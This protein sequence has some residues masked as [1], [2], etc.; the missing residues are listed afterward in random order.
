MQRALLRAAPARDDGSRPRSA[1]GRRT[2]PVARIT[3]A[4]ARGRVA[5]ALVMEGNL[6][7]A[8]NALDAVIAAA[9]RAARSCALELGLLY[10]GFV[11]Y[12][13][14]EYAAAEARL[15]EA[16]LLSEERGD[17]FEAFGAR[18]FVGLARAN[19]GRMSEAL[20]D[21]EHAIVL[22][23]RNGERFWRAAA[24]EPARLGPPR[25]RRAGEGSGI[26]HARLGPRA[27]EPVAL[28]ARGRRAPE[29]LRRRRACRR[30][31]Q[32][33]RRARDAR[34]RDRIAADGC[35]G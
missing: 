18:M 5:Q 28:D 24:G 23:R 9:A 35:A 16:L 2:S 8:R 22:A 13:Q 19:Q 27:R 20:A 30:S 26:R 25:A 7:E 11:H 34:G 14:G 15:A 3:L 10:R 12:W 31:R 32:G 4:E 17:G 6:D 1:A 29:P 21:F 33:R